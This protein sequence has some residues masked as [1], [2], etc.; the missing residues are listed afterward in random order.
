MC[1]PMS[2]SQNG[3]EEFRRAQGLLLL[4][5]MRISGLKFIYTQ[6]HLILN[7]ATLKKNRFG[8][9][10]ELEAFCSD[11]KAVAVLKPRN[12]CFRWQRIAVH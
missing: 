5:A 8:F 9:D 4:S 3:V 12:S 10:G 6:T 1:A 7:E 11:Y 2:V